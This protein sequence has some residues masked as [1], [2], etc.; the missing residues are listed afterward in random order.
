MIHTTVNKIKK[1]GGTVTYA[2]SPLTPP[3]LITFFFLKK[4]K[5]N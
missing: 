5:W 3:S 1:F 4:L 2:G